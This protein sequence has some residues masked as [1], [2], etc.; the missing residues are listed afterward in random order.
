MVVATTPRYL[1]TM[2]QYTARAAPK[3]LRCRRQV[4]RDITELCVKPKTHPRLTSTTLIVR[5][6]AELK[7]R[8]RGQRQWLDIHGALRDLCQNLPG[9]YERA[10]CLKPS[11]ELYDAG[12]P[13]GIRI[14]TPN[15][16][17]R[18]LITLGARLESQRT[19]GSRGRQSIRVSSAGPEDFNSMPSQK[20]GSA[21][22]EHNWLRA[23]C[24]RTP[25]D[26]LAERLTPFVPNPTLSAGPPFFGESSARRS[27]WRAI[28]MR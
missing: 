27:A 5:S 18:V 20:L 13:N 3:S 6:T 26:V 16:V 2:R 21:L 12:Q 8:L 24:N 14:A 22:L 11:C 1:V 4:V 23:S 25:R 19:L 7:A 28:S 10:V 17:A 9:P 15:P